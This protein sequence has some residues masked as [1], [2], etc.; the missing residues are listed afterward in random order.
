M[1]SDGTIDKT[2]ETIV[3]EIGEWMKVNGESIYG[4][5]PWKVYGEGPAA[6]KANP[7]KAQGFN[8][9]AVGN[10]GADDIRFNQKKGT[11]YISFL[12]V[13]QNKEVSVKSCGK[14]AR[15][16]KKIKNIT[17]LGSDEKITWKQNAD[18]LVMSVPSKVPCTQAVV[19]KVT[20]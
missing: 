17:V 12:G 2:E 15:L 14:D 16:L 20:Y 5:T 3:K 8:E 13:P 18:A 1:K 10:L 6:D 4:T 11:L 19:Y 9:G 7:I